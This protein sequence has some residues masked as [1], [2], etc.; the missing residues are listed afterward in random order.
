MMKANH[1]TKMPDS[2]QE[3]ASQ[4]KNATVIFADLSGFTA[5]SANLDPEEVREIVN[6]YFE[7]LAGA[8]RRYEG[9]IDK[10]IGDCVMAVFGVPA[11]RENDAERA[12][13]AAL[14]M[15]SAVRELASGFGDGVEPPDIHIGVNTGL[16]VAAPMGSGDTAQF[17]VMGD[18]V[19]LASRLC[20]EAENGQIAV[21]ESTWALAARDFEFSKEL[22]SIKGKGENVPVY[23]LLGRSQKAGREQKRS[24][25]PMVGR[26]AEISL[27]Q[28]LL[29][30]GQSKHGA[31]LYVTGDPGIGKSRLS[32]EIAK[33][34]VANGYR[35]LDAAAQPL[36]AIEP[37]SLWRQALERSPRVVPG[38]TRTKA[39]AAFADFPQATSADAEQSVALRATLG[40]PT[41]ELELL[42][43]DARF[44]VISRGWKSYMHGLAAHAPLLMIL[45]DLQWSDT[46]S[47][48]L[49]DEV[50]EV[51]PDHALVLCCMARPEF[52]HRWASRSDFHLIELRPL[53]P[54]ECTKL[55]RSLLK[56]GAKFNDAEVVARA[57]GNPFYLTEL[58]QAAA[59]NGD[60]K[61]PP[62]IEAVI[63]ERID[64]LERQSRQLLELASVIGREF[65]ERVLRAVANSEHLESQLPKL[66]E[67]EFIYEKELD[68]ELLYL[69]KHYL[70]QEA[71]YNSILV[72]R[73]KEMHAKV[74]AAIEQIYKDSLE[75]Y[76]AVLAQHYEKAA[77]YRRAF[78]CYRQAG[79]SAQ[80]STGGAAATQFYERGE[81]ALKMLHEDRPALLNKVAAFVVSIAAVLAFLI[82]FA[83]SDART[84]GASLLPDSDY[85]VF[86]A[87]AGILTFV[88]LAY[89]SKRWSFLVYPDRIKLTSKRRSLDIRFDRIIGV[90]VISYNPLQVR[91]WWNQLKGYCDPLYPMYGIGQIH[92]MRR[93]SE[94]LRV[95][96]PHRGWRKGYY[97]NLE[98]PRRFLQTL[99]RALQRYRRVQSSAASE[100]AHRSTSIP[101][102]YV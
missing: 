25:P 63:L 41:P 21:G 42:D 57:E 98:D 51:I 86:L 66:R 6:R 95:E 43:D 73:R 8:V 37:Y 35:V 87:V 85:L 45:D 64:R 12:C 97:L 9:S 11:T 54:E 93:A 79:D 90:E 77:D 60:G 50:V 32:S 71:T 89:W 62:T 67:L 99:N 3:P 70:T 101:D 24:Q 49:L 92:L 74:A 38:M 18:A 76:S 17:T 1:T 91:G 13:R 20:H 22:R 72:K 4:R 7:A 56:D 26:E 61:L 19:N 31:I 78:E 83:P 15:L 65:P 53:S 68:P 81:T 30:E 44:Q 48:R 27:A 5:M 94:I 88:L 36:A 28:K 33:F 10:Y 2:H 96:C 40:L 75:R 55:A 29:A 16:V 102:G 34:A 82:A 23:F 39:D 100:P 47:L 59:R 69:F 84:H 80:G 14:D 52:Q 58:F 46:Y